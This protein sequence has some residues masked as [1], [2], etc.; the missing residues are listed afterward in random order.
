MIDAERKMV[1]EIKRLRSRGFSIAGIA[2]QTGCA[3]AYIA[4]VL[5]EAWAPTPE[6]VGARR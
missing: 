5:H 2:K 1:A 4:G 6:H 3:P